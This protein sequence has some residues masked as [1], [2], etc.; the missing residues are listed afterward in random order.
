LAVEN[1]FGVEI[2]LRSKTQAKSSELKEQEKRKRISALSLEIEAT[3]I[4]RQPFSRLQLKKL[5]VNV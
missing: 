5:G 4:E 3:V 2:T 1:C